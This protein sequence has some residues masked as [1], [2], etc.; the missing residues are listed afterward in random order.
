VEEIVRDM[1]THTVYVYYQSFTHNVHVLW[2]VRVR[3]VFVDT[4]AHRYG[5][6]PNKALSPSLLSL[7]LKNYTASRMLLFYYTEKISVC[8][9]E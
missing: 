8:T 3:G 6:V 7:S 4:P 1:H 2:C 5:A 9:E